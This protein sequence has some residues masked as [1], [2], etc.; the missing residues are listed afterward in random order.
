MCDPNANH[1][2]HSKRSRVLLLD[3]FINV[4]LGLM[5]ATFPD[6]VVRFLGVPA[7]DTRFYTSILGAVLLGIGLALVIEFYRKSAQSPGLGLNGAVAI[8]LCGAV[9]LIGWLLCG[10]LD[11]P[12]RGQVF[13]WVVSI[14]LVTISVSELRLTRRENRSSEDLDAH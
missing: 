14:S 11:I 1:D 8:N 9:F 13:L 10:T 2:L 4:A 12:A 5:L 3:A 6:A 7:T